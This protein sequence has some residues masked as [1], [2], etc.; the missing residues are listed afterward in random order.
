MHEQ[1]RRY[2][3][4]GVVQGVGFRPFIV[5]T[6]ERNALNGWILNDSD[7]VVL[8]IQGSPPQLDTFI[9]EMTT[10]AP[11]L[12]RID[13]VALV[14][15]DGEAPSY[16]EFA[17]RASD[18]TERAHTLVAPDTYVCD[19]CLAELFDEDDRRHRYPLINCTNCGPRYSIIRGVP[20]DRAYTTMSAFPM[21]DAC[22]A[23][24][25]D[26]RDRRFHAQP[27]ACWDCGPQV[28]LLDGRGAD[29]GTLDPVADA[30]SLLA[31]GAILAVKGLG[32]FHL[33][34]DAEN[35][36]A[37]Q[38]L[39]WRKR[40]DEK[41]FALM[42]RTLE[43][44]A[45]YSTMSAA[46][47][48][49]LTST[50]RP[51]VLLPK[52]EGAAIAEGV[53]PGNRRYGVMLAYTPLHH[54]LLAE[55]FTALVATSGNVS[56]EPI[57]F[58][59][60]DALLR[61]ADIADGFLVH[62]RDIYTRVDDSIA[63]VVTRGGEPRTALIRRA[64]GYA[65]EPITAPFELPPVVAVG[66]EL[67]NTICLSRGSELF[68]SQHIGDLK[69]ELTARSFE[70]SIPHLARLLEV[71]PRLLAHDA[72]PG[73]ASSRFAREQRTLPTVAVQHH[74]AHLAACLCEHGLTGPAIGVIFDGTGYGT[75]GEIWG[76]EFLVG[77]YAGF[78]RAAHLEYFRLPGGDRAVREPYRVA[79]AL[80][81]HAHGGSFEEVALP[82]VTDR[83][84]LER[85]TL[86]RMINS[87]LHAPRTSSVG[88]LFDGVAA[89]IGV[90]ERVR[91]EAQAAIELEQLVEPG[92]TAD[93][94][95]WE[96]HLGPGPMRVD[97]APMIRAIAAAAASGDATV[98][99]LSLRF[100]CTVANM[101]LGTCAAIRERTQID[102][103][104][105][106]GGVFLNAVLLQACHD[107][108]RAAGF[109]VYAHERV[110]TNDGG[111]ALGQAAIAGYQAR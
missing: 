51:I 53:A 48:A 80:L 55:G 99:E 25:E 66:P 4:R 90:R 64:R 1:T 107:G 111:V 30:A 19:D 7:G 91:Y 63:R 83:D 100:H 94:W 41:P 84:P 18:R 79:L 108:L 47:A 43:D 65:P 50:G 62:D 20:Y 40:R 46:E 26:V 59:N 97:P 68:L 67:K 109:E 101:V 82:V 38:E 104:A 70:H 15:Q 74:H 54:L 23:E 110:P 71:E 36:E 6:A 92:R 93:P 105:L 45:R 2:Q 95:P 39:R 33:V 88:R 77:D 5:R 10:T 49:L 72:H 58:D 37:V 14:D 13:S 81:A 96:L 103:V 98:A 3:I 52:R 8:E 44:V 85:R 86:G 76:G 42:S 28:R 34:V 35:P 27:V 75:D 17:I 57:A 69:N 78:D 29:R 61:L 73:Y 32:G 56:D 24:Y 31:G 102:R 22:A 11:P 9:L 12:A 106:S 60:D 21:C 16:S 89:L 87:G